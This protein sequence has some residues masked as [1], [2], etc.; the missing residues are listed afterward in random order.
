[1]KWIVEVIIQVS[2]HWKKGGGNRIWLV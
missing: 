2:L 1:M